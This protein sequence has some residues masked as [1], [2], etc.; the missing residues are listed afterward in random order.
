MESVK[1]I[2]PSTTAWKAV[3]LPL[4][5]TDILVKHNPLLHIIG[6][7]YRCNH[8]N[9]I[10]WQDYCSLSAIREWRLRWGLNPRP[11]EWQSSVLADWTTEP[12]NIGFWRE[13]LIHQNSITEKGATPGGLERSDLSLNLQRFESAWRL[14][15]FLLG[16]LSINHLALTKLTSL[17][18]KGYYLT[19]NPERVLT[20]NMPLSIRQPL[21]WATGL[22]TGLLYWLIPLFYW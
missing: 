10:P 4:H 6:I 17:Q 9:S 18:F 21:T 12:Y 1:G 16:G 3:M 5:H 13:P 20:S 14:R 2:E 8:E 11:L 19:I 22:G 7:S 15:T